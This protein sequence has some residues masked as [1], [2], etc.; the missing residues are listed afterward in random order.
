MYIEHQEKVQDAKTTAS[1]GRES[2][3]PRSPGMRFEKNTCF[4]CSCP[5]AQ[6]YPLSTVLTHKTDLKLYEAVILSKNLAWK[7]KG[8]N[9]FQHGQLPEQMTRVYILPVIPAGPNDRPKE[10]L[11]PSRGA[12]TGA[13][14]K[15]IIKQWNEWD[16]RVHSN[17]FSSIGHGW[18]MQDGLM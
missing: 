7:I 16:D 12:F 2:P 9:T 15:R 14:K 5:E 1:C 18:V 4:F 10:N 13:I 6:K 17:R 8:K 3:Y 11:P